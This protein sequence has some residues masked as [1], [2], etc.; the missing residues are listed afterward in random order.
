MLEPLVVSLTAIRRLIA[1]GDTEVALEKLNALLAL[2]QD[3]EAH[4]LRLRLLT[5]DLHHPEWV[6]ESLQ[7]ME[8]HEPNWPALAET[9]KTLEGSIGRHLDS[10]REQ[11]GEPGNH[12]LLNAADELLPLAD[13]FPLI[14]LTRGL[15]YVDAARQHSTLSGTRMAERRIS[16]RPP[17]YKPQELTQNAE[18]SLEAALALLPAD[19]PA[20]GEAW[21]L[22]GELYEEVSGN[23]N[24]ALN[25]YTHAE[26]AGL[27]LKPRIERVVQGIARQTLARLSQ[28][29]DGLLER[30]E[31]QRAATLLKKCDRLDNLPAVR[32]R[33]ADWQLLTGRLDEAEVSYKHLLEIGDFGDRLAA[34]AGAIA[35]VGTA[36]P[37]E[38]L[39]PLATGSSLPWAR[40]AIAHDDVKSRA[41]SGLI[42][43][44]QRQ[45]AYE[46]MRET[47][48]SVLVTPGLASAS[49]AAL[50][51]DLKTSE[52]L[53][54]EHGRRVL[55][56]RRAALWEAE[57]W[58]ALL[59][60]CR[61]LV[62]LPGASDVDHVWL[63]SALH[64]RGE[65]PEAL[66]HLLQQ[67][68]PAALNA[69][70]GGSGRGL[71]RDLGQ[72][73]YWHVT[74]R[75][76]TALPNVGNWR[77]GYTARRNAYL[78]EALAGAEAA[79]HKGDL[80]TAESGAQR[81]LQTAPDHAQA[82]LLLGRIHSR[83]G[84]L[85]EAQQL[86]LPLLEKP[87][88]HHVTA[89]ALAEID[90]A[91]G[92]L[93]DA[94]RKIDALNGAG[95][96]TEIARL[97]ETLEHRIQQTPVVQVEMIDAPVSLDTLRR[98]QNRTC[99][100]ATFGVSLVS[101]RAVRNTP[102]VDQACA[103]LLTALSQ[104]SD[105][106]GLS[107]RFAWRYIG[108]RGMLRV[109]LLCGVE[110]D[111]AELA[112]MAAATLWHT[113]QEMLPLQ[114]EQVYGYAPVMSPD[115]L[116]QLRL[117]ASVG[118]AV[119]VVRREMVI[120]NGSAAEVYMTYPFT[121]HDGDMR[122]LLR[123]LA[124]QPE[125]T[126]LDVHFQPTRLF[127]WERTV[128]K[129]MLDNYDEGGERRFN[130]E[131]F[132]QA[133]HI[134]PE[135]MRHAQW[136]AFVVRIHLASEGDLHPAL[137]NIAAT[138]LFGAS[139]YDI[140][141][142]HFTPEL[143]AIERNLREVNCSAW[144]YSAAPP[145]LERLRYLLTPAETL[146]A[147]RLPTPGV[148]GLPGIPALK[149]KAA[150]LPANLPEN[151]TLIGESVTPVRGR[152][153]PLRLKLADRMRHAYVVGR[154]G[155]GK[156]TLLQNMALQD[157]EAGHGVGVID[158]HGDLV[159]A[160]LERIP[161]H[162]LQ[163]VV[164]FDPSDTER[165][166]GLN[167]LDVTG[168]FEQNM[169][170]AEF[171]GLMYSMFDPN[172]LGIVGPRFENAVRNAMLTAMAIPGST[173]VEVVRILSDRDYL[174]QCLDVISD[175]V[176]AAYW[177]DI[178]GNMSD[179]HRSEVLDYITS[180]FGRFVT[181][182]LVRNIIG[183]SQN[184]LD[185]A[186]I[187]NR[188]QILLV[189]LAKGKIGPANSH[190]LG[191]L[192]VPR[193]LIAALSRAHMSAAE[194]RLF[195]LYVDEFHNFTTPAFS[196]MLSEARKYGMALTVANQFIS[197]L[198]NS[199]REAVFGNV[200]TMLAFQVGVKD[201]HYLAPEMYPVFD[202]D[203]MVNLPN[204]H[205]LAKI[206]VDGNVMPQFPARTVP[207]PRLPNRELAHMIR[208]ASRQR[209]G[210]DAFIVGHEI[211]QRYAQPPE[212]R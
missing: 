38:V 181:D 30:G 5:A 194:R 124:E 19:S 166:V 178:V 51:E 18:R 187:M 68:S 75:C 208:Q 204:Y 13:R 82:A 152:P 106:L 45:N 22:L 95:R 76:I 57:E 123:V 25:A 190:F 207:D 199:I 112:R 34:Y 88:M 44:Y 85:A 174:R 84:R 168:T 173:L 198:D 205:L 212:G 136:M 163:D 10:L 105:Q 9:R 144:G 169:V 90:I 79:F 39:A 126:V 108:G 118:S 71:L 2:R 113:L 191:L 32:L 116:D 11:L 4:G 186:G 64:Q 8:Q 134:Y 192:L 36:L 133:S 97:A 125:V 148:D 50:L 56:A 102:D 210:R 28:H 47:I 153:L 161:A 127:A 156:S 20:R 92:Y 119:E 93:L 104:A 155:T 16:E 183:Q 35:A 21:Q 59:S 49:V 91:Q 66:A 149:V 176:V 74:D 67:V 100:L 158:P 24:A 160:I 99:W 209:Y 206:M 175:P 162:R 70:P 135:F 62:S 6:E 132:Q 146:G 65:A 55:E 41:W 128:I 131:R 110:A 189:N 180:K 73:G 63:I 129:T 122:R 170:V 33:R 145:R 109:V 94:R 17:R 164:L 81:V 86:L 1:E 7:W 147:T 53:A 167:I 31:Y 96:E 120:D 69:L 77:K 154:T 177:K 202:V 203:D 101:V 115:E 14:H 138:G 171:I 179:F 15:V 200:G 117:P 195:C 196:V 130:D 211:Q 12:T 197:Q 72:A 40:Y 42:V 201:A 107:A 27:A 142:A 121:R 98:T 151:G 26:A 165:P 60:T 80:E 43:T 103:E 78:S 159:E 61:Q 182:H 143:E 37:D 48:R 58:D 185:F 157:I 139:R 46:R 52:K 137:P 87:D 3:A 150:P 54:A 141:P 140:I 193:L 111:S 172:K 114:D 89:L 188:G 23:L 29:L 184:T 83:T